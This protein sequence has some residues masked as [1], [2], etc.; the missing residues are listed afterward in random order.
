M[1]KP[2]WIV[3]LNGKY[4][5]WRRPYIT[6]WN[7]CKETEHMDKSTDLTYNFQYENPGMYSDAFRMLQVPKGFIEKPV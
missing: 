4:K 2:V 7:I 5:R 3:K 6:K 1:I